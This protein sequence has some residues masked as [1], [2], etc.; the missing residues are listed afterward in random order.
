LTK[1][2]RVNH[3][4]AIDTTPTTVLEAPLDLEDLGPLSPACASFFAELCNPI[5]PQAIELESCSNPL[6]IQQVF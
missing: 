2:Y 6:R 1:I 3:I 5:A 4:P